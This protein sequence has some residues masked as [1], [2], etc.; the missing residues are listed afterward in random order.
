VSDKSTLVDVNSNKIDVL[1][2]WLDE[3]RRLRLGL[4]SLGLNDE[5][6]LRDKPGKTDMELRV[7]A[8]LIAERYSGGTQEPE[9]SMVSGIRVL[10]S[11]P[12]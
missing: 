5:N 10:T 6:W 11:S 1:R 12:N 4:E 8:K 7:L 2:I 9:H 3:R